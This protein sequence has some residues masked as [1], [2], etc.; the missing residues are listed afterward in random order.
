MSDSTTRPPTQPSVA[1]DM[2][3]FPGQGG[4]IRAYLARPTHSGPHPGVLLCHENRG[5][6][7]HFC[8]VARRLA[9]AGYVALAVDVLSREGGT[10]AVD[11]ATIPDLLSAMPRE[12]IVADFRAG[13]QFLQAQPD[14]RA[15][16][17][18]M[19]GFCFGGGIT[20]RCATQLPELRAAVPFYG[21]N[22]PLEDVPSTQ[23][24]VLA[25][26]G[27]HDARINAG[28]DAIT[29]EM[30]AHGKTFSKL[31]YPGADHAFF[32]DTGQRYHPDAAADAW[33]RLL[34]WFDYYLQM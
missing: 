29:A 9:D 31:V 1:A 2:T 27:E 4:E 6:L 24:A 34:A 17:I 22:P 20:W 10:D 8:D 14:V 3:T 19:V 32:N 26:Y 12:Q 18:G 15:D 13:A 23:C 16:R 28:I 7:P 5:L 21:P 11:A 33:A 25:L 30:V